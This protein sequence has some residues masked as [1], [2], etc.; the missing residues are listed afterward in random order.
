MDEN[1]DKTNQKN[2]GK[3]GKRRGITIDQIVH[4]TEI[5]GLTIQ[6]TA[7]R[8]NC[9][10]SNI[11][12]H[13]QRNE[14]TPGYLAEFEKRKHLVLAQMQERILRKITAEDIQ[15]ASLQQKVV[16]AS[17]LI[18]KQL[19]LE[20]K[21]TAH[22]AYVDLSGQADRLRQE[23]LAIATQLGLSETDSDSDSDSD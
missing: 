1:S 21:A 17:V 13:L 3:R 15:K 16:S 2:H 12:R 9:D 20:G 19:L 11:V 8:L 10:H 4:C 7:E 14:I 6:Q 22:I 5:E 23:R 18:D